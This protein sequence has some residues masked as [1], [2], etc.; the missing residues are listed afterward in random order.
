[1][2]EYLES[3]NMDIDNLEKKCRNEIPE[4]LSEFE[5]ARFIYIW[6]GKKLSLDEN[7]FFGDR[8]ERKNI[9]RV[10]QNAKDIS[11]LTNIIKDNKV[12]CVTATYLYT[13]MLQKSGIN[14]F[15]SYPSFNNPHIYTKIILLDGRIIKAD[16]QK[17]I[18]NIQF[19]LKT[20]YFGND[21]E[22]NYI[23]EKNDIIDADIKL[24][25]IKNDYKNKIFKFIKLYRLDEN[26]K[27]SKENLK[28]VLKSLS[29]SFD[30]AGK[31]IMEVQNFYKIALKDIFDNK[32]IDNL[33][34][35]SYYFQSNGNKR[36]GQFILYKDKDEGD[37]LFVYDEN[38]QKFMEIT[39]DNLKK[40]IKNGLV[41]NNRKQE[42]LGLKSKG[43]R[44]KFLGKD[45]ESANYFEIE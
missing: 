3:Y 19:G 39:R 2:L 10:S 18:H 17:D 23:I 16:L 32:N 45:D 24:G 37:S 7:Y 14:A 44:S 13:Y 43:K 26:N 36:Y 41:I 4:N 38:K 33:K 20:K 9:L 11:S 27:M 21:Y 30:F 25:Y 15:I 35:E 29:E 40:N 28:K 8:V 31:G 22:E 12:I 1:M 6:L 42:I 5:K 34:F